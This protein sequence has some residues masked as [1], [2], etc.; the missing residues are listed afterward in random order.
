MAAEAEVRVELLLEGSKPPF[1][2]AENLRSE[3]GLVGEVRVRRSAPKRE[4]AAERRRARI[5]V[6][7]GKGVL[8]LACEPLE[9]VEVELAALDAEDVAAAPALDTVATEDLAKP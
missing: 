3:P 7:P 4:R 5:Y 8:R 2:E 9:P 6:G 1:L